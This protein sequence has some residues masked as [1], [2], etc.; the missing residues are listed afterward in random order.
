M[1]GVFT[2]EIY[3]AGRALILAAIVLKVYSLAKSAGERNGR[4]IAL[5]D[6]I[7]WCAGFAIFAALIQGAPSCDSGGDP[8]FGFCERSD[9]GQP[10][11]STE[12]RAATFL[13]WSLVLMTPV[14]VGAMQSR[15]RVGRSSEN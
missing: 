12:Q 3:D 10:E 8:L 6:G 15:K 14:A 11:V 7:F 13:F 1:S 5:R 2:H 9:D 4:L